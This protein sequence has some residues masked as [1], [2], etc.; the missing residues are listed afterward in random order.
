MKGKARVTGKPAID[1]PPFIG[2]LNI[3]LLEKPWIDFKF[4]GATKFLAKKLLSIL[5]DYI[6]QYFNYPNSVT[7]PLDEAG[8]VLRFFHLLKSTFTCFPVDV[9]LIKEMKPT[10]ILAVSVRGARNLT[11]ESDFWKK[12]TQFDQPDTYVETKFGN[13]LHSTNMVK[14]DVDPV[15]EDKW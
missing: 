10:G 9:R 15:F 8:L 4:V 11:R 3:I 12:L 7:M 5:V 6:D 1:R 14:N 13:I 2:G